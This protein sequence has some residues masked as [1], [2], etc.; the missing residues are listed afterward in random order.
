MIQLS[1]EDKYLGLTLG[2]GLTLK[3]QVDKVANH[4]TNM[5]NM[6]ESGVAVYDQSLENNVSMG[7]LNMNNNSIQCLNIGREVGRLHHELSL[8]NEI[9]K[10]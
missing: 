3:I 6:A 4:V 8:A 10:L 2:R 9:I 5:S 7:K 1:I